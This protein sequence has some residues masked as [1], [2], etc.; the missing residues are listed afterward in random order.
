[1]P[2]LQV[3]PRVLCVYMTSVTS[4]PSFIYDTCEK[5]IQALAFEICVCDVSLCWFA[6]RKPKRIVISM[7][8][9]LALQSTGL[10]LILF[11]FLVVMSKLRTMAAL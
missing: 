4:I 2:C 6:R 8:L 9:T 10:P 11:Y 3:A 5:S 1:V 7:K